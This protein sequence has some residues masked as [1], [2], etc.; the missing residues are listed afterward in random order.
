MPVLMLSGK[1]DEI[2]PKEHMR[3][4]ELLLRPK[5]EEGVKRAG[6]FIEFERGAHSTPSSFR[7]KSNFTDETDCETDDTCV[8]PGYWSAV[9]NFIRSLTS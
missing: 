6:S 8:Q 1:R 2:V 9:A 5:D 7:T 3:E 4:L